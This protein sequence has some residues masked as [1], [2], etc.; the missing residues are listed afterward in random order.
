M[1]PNQ[2]AFGRRLFHRTFEIF[3][4]LL[5][6]LAIL[7]PFILSFR[8]PTAVAYAVLF[9]DVY[10]L[11]RCL[12]ISAGVIIG[13]ERYSKAVN[14]DWLSQLKENFPQEL[15]DLYHLIVIPT[16]K[17][18]AYIIEPTIKAIAESMY[19]LNHIYIVLGFEG[20]DD[21]K[22]VAEVKKIVAEK[23]GQKFGGFVTTVHPLGV[24][25]TW[26][27]ASNRTYAIKEFLKQYPIDP[28]KT[29][30]T[31]LDSDFRLHPQFLAGAI[32]RYLTIPEQER[33]KRSYTG[34]FLYNNNYWET[35]APMRVNATSTAFWQLSEMV[36]SGK[37]MN[38]ASMTINLQAVIDMN[39]WPLNVINDDSA[40]YW[41]AYYHFNGDYKVL[42]HYLP[43]SADAVQDKTTLT[44]YKNQYQQ[45]QRW[46]Y[47][48]E[49]LPF[50]VKNSITRKAIPI[51]HRLDHLYFLILSNLSWAMLGFIVTF[52]G[53]LLP[54]INPAFKQTVIGYNFP[55][56][57]SYILTVS[58]LGLFTSVWVET[59]LTPPR[60]KLWP[61]WKKALTPLQWLL[62]PFLIIIFGTI[63]ALDAQTRLMLGKY[64][65]FQVTVK[66]RKQA[67]VA[68]KI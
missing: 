39:Y 61:W 25:E 33:D 15:Q 10:W 21:P 57:S 11:Y 48:I 46:A 45:Y 8:I 60:P 63:P 68:A 35:I 49:H 47:G 17:E 29:L 56:L 34:V 40:F 13:Y 44:T 55:H 67:H 58:L 22:R 24:G 5:S 6:W 59:K 43:I 4:G 54:F 37:Y 38:F 41:R 19:P 66:E 3:P 42:P 53:I 62:T 31:T 2:L 23:Y 30:L 18:E 51:L 26:G 28:R 27:P 7:S 20:K 12:R 50:V 16:L 65:S 14:T 52:G 9:L 64:L 1:S 36:T 32:F